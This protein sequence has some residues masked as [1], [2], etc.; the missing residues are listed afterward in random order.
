MT[1]G[2]GPRLAAAF[3]L[4][5]A[6]TL[7]SRPGYVGAQQRGEPTPQFRSGVTAV[8][9]NVRVL[10]S[11]GKPIT[12]LE[13]SDFTILEDGVPQA[14]ALFSAHVL[15][16]AA[17]TRD[18]RANATVEPFDSSPQSHR[19]FLLVLGWGALGDARRHPESVDALVSFVRGRLLPQDQVA[20]L[21]YNRGVDFTTDHEKVAR[22]LEAFKGPMTPPAL[23]PSPDPAVPENDEALGFEAYVRARVGQPMGE[24]D[25]LLYGIRYLQQLPGEK[26]LVFISEHGPTTP[27]TADDPTLDTWTLSG[28]LRQVAKAAANARVALDTIQ[29]GQP[30]IDTMPKGPPGPGAAAPLVRRFGGEDPTTSALVGG[31]GGGANA[32]GSPTAPYRERE[33][34]VIGMRG[35][36]AGL[37]AVYDLK[38]TASQTGGLSANWTDLA[39]A[40]ARIDTASR[41]YY[42]LAYYPT[43][44]NWN[45]R[46]R[47]VKVAVNRPG[48]TV[49][50]RHGYFASRAIEVFDRRRVVSDTRIESAAWQLEDLRELDVQVRTAFV[51][52][53]GKPGGELVVELSLDTSRLGWKVDADGLHVASVEVAIYATDIGGDNLKV[54]GEVRR[55]LNLKLTDETH[56]R[57]SRE[58]F[59]RVLRM[60][61]TGRPRFAKVIVYDYDAD[62]VGSVMQP[63]K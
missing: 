8:P 11:S 16:P 49:L 31:G 25:S 52:A 7:A 22:E 51:K 45:G 58:R 12:N 1:T 39:P 42:L 38:F 15:A 19:V 43:N 60:P 62:R 41:A 47:S 3:T 20:L 24:V 6:A 2:V 61:V 55:A 53:A 23:I 21:G 13:K 9:I 28:N 56:D 27:A 33:A 63:V 54:L 17:P 48:A 4:L 44:G 57:V 5:V 34:F 37:N 10:D 18:L 26:H 35:P 32:L 30:I 29:L 40:L 46:Y 59:T 50:F 14:V 36:L